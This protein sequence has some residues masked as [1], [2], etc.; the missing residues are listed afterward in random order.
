MSDPSSPAPSPHA[1]H[2]SHP[3]RSAHAPGDEDTQVAEARTPLPVEVAVGEPARPRGQ[4]PLSRAGQIAVTFAALTAIPYL[5]PRLAAFRLFGKPPAAPQSTGL[6]AEYGDAKLAAGKAEPPPVVLE[7]PPAEPQVKV[8]AGK[9]AP[10]VLSD[11]AVSVGATFRPIEDPTGH[12]LDGFFAALA[13]TEKG[14]PGALTRVAHYGDSLVVSD[15]MSSTLRRRFQNKFGDAGH[16]FVLFAKPWAWYFHQDVNHWNGEGWTANRVV[17]PRIA[18]EMYGYGGATFRTTETKAN[19]GFS[20]AKPTPGDPQAEKDMFGRRVSR[21][22]VHYLEQPDGGSVHVSIDG[23]HVETLSTRAPKGG[24]KKLAQKTYPVADGEHSIEFRPLGGA[25]AR[26]FGTVL[27]RDVAGVVWDALGVNGGRARLLDVNDTTHWT[28]ALRARNP[29][30]VVLQYGTNESE[31]T[32]YP[33]EQ[34]E[35]TLEQ[36]LRHVRAALPEA[37]CLVVGTMDRAGAGAGGMETRPIIPLLGA[38]Q[39][40]VAFKVG[41]AF[42]DTLASM[43]GPGSMGRWV[44]ATPKL[45]GGDLTHPTATGAALLGDLLY[46]ALMKAYAEHG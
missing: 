43:G 36:V 15:F 16:G 13:K 31:D 35:A 5:H 11:V 9:A 34:Y 26:F 44:K 14:E 38:A 19:A 46:T 8:G 18:D 7:A 17:N 20:T 12:A 22:E 27:E 37:G 23:K 42:W 1:A 24:S 28:E 32:G 45:G 2:P 6:A 40:K 10:V 25:E 21:F 33:M 39:R 4:G 3:S 29:N 41:C 30:L